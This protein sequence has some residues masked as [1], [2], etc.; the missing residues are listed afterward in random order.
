MFSAD[1]GETFE[2]QTN[3]DRIWNI[4]VGEKTGKWNPD[5]IVV[6]CANY[7]SISEEPYTDAPGADGNGSGIAAILTAARA[8]SNIDTQRTL[9]YICLPSGELGRIGGTIYADTARH[10]GDHILAVVNPALIGTKYSI[11]VLLDNFVSY[12]YIDAS[13]QDIG[14]D[15]IDLAG[16]YEI[17]VDY[18]A[19]N[20][21]DV[22]CSDYAAFRTVDYP[23]V[24]LTE[25]LIVPYGDFPN[26]LYR[27][28]G[29]LSGSL[30]R[31]LLYRNTLLT[32]AAALHLARI[33]TQG[34]VSEPYPYGAVIVYPNPAHPGRGDTVTFGDILP[35]FTVEVFN[36]SGDRVFYEEGEG[37]I[38]STWNLRCGGEAVAAG[39]YIYR[40]LSPNGSET[41]KLAVLK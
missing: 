27:T 33:Y 36:L 23:A 22:V 18:S 15:I 21:P 38:T 37:R 40:I 9:R 39:I 17:D 32:T 5:E 24:L 19:I 20:D 30:Q 29:D 10:K 11:S 13:S 6:F 2:S 7:D 1:G 8:T 25:A 3:F 26:P 41:G 16:I 34:T 4:V 28:T 14:Q 12:C 35:P 31:D